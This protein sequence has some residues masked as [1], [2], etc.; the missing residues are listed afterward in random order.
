MPEDPTEVGPGATGKLLEQVVSRLRDQRFLFLVA[1]IIALAVLAPLKMI[2]TST[3]IIIFG[4]S[5]GVVLVDRVFEFLGRRSRG[6]RG[7]VGDVA[8]FIAPDFEG[9]SEGTSVQLNERAEYT[10]QDPR[11]PGHPEVKEVLLLEGPG[12]TGWLCPITSEAGP[13]DL[14]SFTFTAVD[15]RKWR[16]NVVTNTLWPRKTARRIP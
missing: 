12:E 2:S 1:V 9:V 13:N 5:A 7:D 8:M 14:V 3:V 11:N 15:G 6:V 10:I 4:I 16:L